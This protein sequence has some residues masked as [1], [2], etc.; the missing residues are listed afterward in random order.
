MDKF[1]GRNPFT[2]YIHVMWK[3][4]ESA[5]GLWI[6]WK[7]HQKDQRGVTCHLLLTRQINQPAGTAGKS[8]WPKA[9]NVFI[10]KQRGRNYLIEG[11]AAFSGRLE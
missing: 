5:P 11:A 7:K 3:P 2:M 9:S 6:F 4:Q 10:H 1:V 8:T